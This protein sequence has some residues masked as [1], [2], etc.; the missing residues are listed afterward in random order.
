MLR[1]LAGMDLNIDPEFQIRPSSLA[2]VYRQLATFLV[3]DKFSMI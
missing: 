3:R 2:T 1:F